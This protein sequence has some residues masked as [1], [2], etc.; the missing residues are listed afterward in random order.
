[1]T[2]FDASA[3][4]HMNNPS[5]VVFYCKTYFDDMCFLMNFILVYRTKVY[6][7]DLADVDLYI[8]GSSENHVHGGQVGPTFACIITM[9]FRNKR[10]TDRFWHENPDQFHP[11]I[12]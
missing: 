2:V 1:M 10:F 3:L 4:K 11:G 9:E 7:S 8:A 12:T 5:F 6:C